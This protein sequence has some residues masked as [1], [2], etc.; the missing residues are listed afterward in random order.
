MKIIALEEQKYKEKVTGAVT[1]SAVTTGF[2]SFV[3]Q[4]LTFFLSTLGT[5][6]FIWTRKTIVGTLAVLSLNKNITLIKKI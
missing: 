1:R 6:G 4:N 5:L 2:F 3:S